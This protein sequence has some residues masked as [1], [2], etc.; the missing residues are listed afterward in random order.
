[1]KKIYIWAYHI[2]TAENKR[3]RNFQRRE[4]KLPIEEQHR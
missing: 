3:Q 1:M 2:Q 4:E